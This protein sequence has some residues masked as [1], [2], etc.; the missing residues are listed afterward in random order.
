ML[1]GGDQRLARRLLDHLHRGL[2]RA[3]SLEPVLRVAAEAG[4]L[5]HVPVPGDLED[6]GGVDLGD[7]HVQRAAAVGGGEPVLPREGELAVTRAVVA[8]ED[9]AFRCAHASIIVTA[10]RPGQGLWS[11]P[12][13]AQLRELVVAPPADPSPAASPAASPSGCQPVLPGP[14]A[15]PGGSSPRS[16]WAARRTPCGGPAGTA[17]GARGRAGGSRARCP[18]RLVPG[19]EDDVRLRHREP[20]RVGRYDGG[21]RDRRGA[22]SAPT[23]ARTG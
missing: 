21:L 8:D 20:D 10:T 1:R 2:R 5:L 22:R 13:G 16:S 7:H 3:C 17:P 23:R 18:G 14:A 12:S 9:C 15:R 4:H 11:R 19:G 6:L